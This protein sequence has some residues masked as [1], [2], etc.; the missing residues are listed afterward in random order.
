M[1]AEAVAS[2]EEALRAAAALRLPKPLRDV[3]RRLAN[4]AGHTAPALAARAL[5]LEQSARVAWEQTQQYLAAGLPSHASGELG[6]MRLREALLATAGTRLAV[7]PDLAAQLE[8][9]T[10]ALQD[11][12]PAWTRLATDIAVP[13]GTAFLLLEHRGEGRLAG[14][15]LSGS[16][17]GARAAQVAVSEEARAQLAAKRTAFV[18]SLS[19]LSETAA[20]GS[21]ERL[22]PAVGVSETQRTETDGGGGTEQRDT[23]PSLPAQESEVAFRALVE[24]TEAYLGPLLDTLTADAARLLDGV[25][26]GALSPLGGGSTPRMLPRGLC[27]ATHTS[28]SGCSR[29]L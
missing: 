17:P 24:A 13:P 15:L 9:F 2:A 6:V 7:S 26:E 19:L 1:R 23:D 10:L 20:G 21:G 28:T 5:V 29:D 22:P 3:A 27:V 4:L 8:R 12:V 11:R 14:A 16:L 25:S 18:D